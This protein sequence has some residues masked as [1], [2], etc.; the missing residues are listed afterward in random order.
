MV[1]LLSNVG[2]IRVSFVSP[3]VYKA[4]NRVIQ[5]FPKLLQNDKV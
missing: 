5:A 2:E 1:R 4:K 3:I